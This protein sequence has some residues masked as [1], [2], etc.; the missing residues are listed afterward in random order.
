[1]WRR[2]QGLIPEEPLQDEKATL[3][4][5]ILVA[6]GI[7]RAARDEEPPRFERFRERVAASPHYQAIWRK[8]YRRET[9]TSEM[10]LYRRL[11]EATE[12]GPTR[13]TTQPASTAPARRV[14][15]LPLLRST[16]PTRAT[17]PS[18]VTTLPVGR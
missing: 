8:E 15:K 18:R 6:P 14:R 16:V 1:L 13:Q 17:L 12:P 5:Y 7:Q 4:G 2:S 3:P 11:A 10:V 9:G